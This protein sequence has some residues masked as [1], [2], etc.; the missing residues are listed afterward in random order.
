MLQYGKTRYSQAALTGIMLLSLSGCL[1]RPAPSTASA[2]LRL[3]LGLAYLA[4]GDAANAARNLRKAL[5][6]APDAWQTQLAMALYWQ[7]VVQPRQAEAFYR[8]ALQRQPGNGLVLNKYG[9]FLC[10]QG[11][12]EQAQALFTKAQAI[13]ADQ[14]QRAQ[15]VLNA[16]CC[17][18]ASQRPEAA[19]AKLQHLLTTSADAAALLLS[20]AETF[21]NEGE[22]SRAGFLLDGYQSRYPDSAKSLW[23]AIRFAALTHQPEKR[24]QYGALLMRS[25]PQSDEYQQFLANEY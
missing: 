20:Q 15:A 23:L 1:A 8:R 2:P 12:H 10:G 21:L 7:R 13:A 22:P 17:D 4:E 25:F 6:A 19:Q 11:R 14:T 24:Q 5:A 3:Q 9:M 18:Y 16:A